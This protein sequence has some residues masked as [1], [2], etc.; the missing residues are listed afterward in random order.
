MFGIVRRRRPFIHAHWYVPLIDFSSDTEHFYK[1]IEDELAARQVP[2]VTV[3]R[4]DLKQAGWFSG[5]RTYL[6][7][8]RE[9]VVLDICSSAFGTGWYYSCR[10]AE[11]PRH[12]RGW[13]VYLTVLVLGVTFLLYWQL[14]GL[15][16]GSVVVGSSILLLLLVF[17]AAR[18]WGT[19]DEFLI[20]LPVMGALYEAY[21][22][23]DTYQMQDQRL[24]YAD[25]VSSVVRLK[26]IEFCAAGGVPEPEFIKVD[27]PDQILTKRELAKY[28][29]KDGEKKR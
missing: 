29:E 1:S 14:Y 11:L 19:L 22:R 26:V 18:S 23:R 7:L 3:E 5:K 2:E 8:L 6:R 17:L 21:F 24:M 15:I 13:Q 27:S 12:M 4:I 9:R 20:Y 28:L 16:L 10:A 25:I